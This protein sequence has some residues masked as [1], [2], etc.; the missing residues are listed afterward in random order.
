MA[1]NAPMRDQTVTPTDLQL[2][3]VAFLYSV[4]AL[5]S[6]G[7]RIGLRSSYYWPTLR[8]IVDPQ[9]GIYATKPLKR[10]L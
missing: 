10:T 4:E 1:P 9:S 3:L 2:R 7:V 6:N 8:K 5:V